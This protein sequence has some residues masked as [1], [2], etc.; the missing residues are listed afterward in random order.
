[1]QHSQKPTQH[2]L[3]FNTSNGCLHEHLHCT[4]SHSTKPHCSHVC[5]CVQQISTTCSDVNMVN[6]QPLMSLMTG[7]Q[8]VHLNKIKREGIEKGGRQAYALTASAWLG[9]R[10]QW[11]MQLTK[12]PASEANPIWGYISYLLP[13]L[14]LRCWHIH[15]MKET[16]S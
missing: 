2:C 11:E 3:L 10:V 12:K 16:N 6:Q 9:S 5:V 8:A 1:M 13:S 4:P 14:C 7:L 15:R